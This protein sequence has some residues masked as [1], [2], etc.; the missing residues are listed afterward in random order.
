MLWLRKIP[1]LSLILILLS[2][3]VFGWYLG[4]YRHLIHS[5]LLERG[6]T[7][8]WMLEE[9]AAKSLIQ[10]LQILITVLIS[11]AL[12]A[13]IALITLFI[14]SGIKTNRKGLLAILAWSI[15]I[16]LAIRWFH[17]FA[18]VLVLFCA[19]LLGQLE[20]QGVGYNEGQIT[21]ILTLFC[22]MGI[23]LGWYFSTYL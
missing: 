7:W 17:Y 14:G 11:L 22:F 1:W 10:I 12:M 8:E 21:L 19:L 15:V 13:P 20:L 6:E 4:E 9:E 23:S 2:Y 16:I 18:N 3:G 5:W